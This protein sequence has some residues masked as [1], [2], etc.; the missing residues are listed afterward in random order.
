MR[1][2]S[3]HI[4][5]LGQGSQNAGESCR[6]G[7]NLSDDLILDGTR[8]LDETLSISDDGLRGRGEDRRSLRGTPEVSGSHA[9]GGQVSVVDWCRSTEVAQ[10]G[11]EAGGETEKGRHGEDGEEENEKVEASGE[12]NA[13]RNE[14]PKRRGGG[15]RC[16]GV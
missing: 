16:G 12:R 13:G 1:I 4:L 10:H 7:L 2:Q 14:D 5:I 3:H 8:G 9:G 11:R 15:M 6:L